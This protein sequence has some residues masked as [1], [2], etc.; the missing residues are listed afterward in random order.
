MPQAAAAPTAPTCTWEAAYPGSADQLR[1]VRADVRSVMADCP[2][3]ADVVTVISEM[4]ANAV[5]HSDSGQPGGTFTVRV[6]HACGDHVRA[7]VEDQ[8]SDWDGDLGGSAR[9]P[10]G[11]YLVTALAAT[12]GTGR[13]PGRSRL[14]WACIA[15]PSRADRS[16][17]R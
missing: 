16:V 10:H 13:G 9:H 12:C 11:L 7:E 6:S 5:T 8:G 14:V 15:D 1:Q 3:A 2:V 4:A 17:A